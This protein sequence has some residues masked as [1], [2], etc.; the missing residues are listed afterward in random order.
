MA[1]A[2]FSPCDPRTL[3]RAACE[4]AVKQPDFA[5]ETGLLALHWLVQGHG[6]DVT[7][8]DVWA[9]YSS[10]IQAAQNRGNS[11]EVRDRVRLI[12]AAEAPGGFVTR[13]LGSELGL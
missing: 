10:T 2:S 1:V 5:I 12:I 3:T 11:A 6:Y 7:S 4:L 9:A 13:I 8:A